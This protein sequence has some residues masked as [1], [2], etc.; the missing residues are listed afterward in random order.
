MGEILCKS[1]RTVLPPGAQKKERRSGK[2]LTMYVAI[3]LNSV[4]EIFLEPG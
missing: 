3:A 1:Q 4:L 2:A